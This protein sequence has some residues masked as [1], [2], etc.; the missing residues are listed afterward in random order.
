MNFFNPRK[1]EWKH[2]RKLAKAHRY[3]VIRLK[4][5]YIYFTNKLPVGQLTQKNIIVF[6]Q[7]KQKIMTPEDSAALRSWAAIEERIKNI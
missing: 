5:Q 7:K 3:V 6:N 4:D 2:Y 1:I